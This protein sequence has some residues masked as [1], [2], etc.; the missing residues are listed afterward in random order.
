MYGNLKAE[1]ARKGL[2]LEKVV[3]ELSKRDIK[4]RVATLSMKLNKQNKKFDFTL[5][6]AVALKSILGVDT[7]IEELF[8][9]AV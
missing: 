4:M 6:E 2:T 9:E 1:F 5:N 7:P 8:K 3:A